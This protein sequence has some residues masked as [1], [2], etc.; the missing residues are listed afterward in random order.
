MQKESFHPVLVTGLG[1]V[2]A[3]GT[4]G[5]DLA[6]LQR[7]NILE[8]NKTALPGEE[9]GQITDFDKET[10]IGRRGLRYHTR[11]TLYLMAAA[12]MA[13]E[14]AGIANPE[15]TEPI[16]IV[17]G[18]MTSNA[19]LVADFDKT[20]LSENPT[21]VNA[22]KFPETVWNSPPSRA[23]IRFGLSGM[24]IPVCCG[25]N[26]GLDAILLGHEHIRNGDENIVLAGG[27]EEMTPYF[28]VLFDK[29]TVSPLSEGSA[30]LV[31]EQEA[32]ARARNSQPLAKI[33]G[34][35]SCYFP[36]QG[37]TA[38]EH[39]TLRRDLV[40]ETM[41]EN[42][43]EPAQVGIIWHLD[44]CEKHGQDQ[45]LLAI[46]ALKW[47]GPLPQIIELTPHVGISGGLAGALAAAIACSPDSKPLAQPNDSPQREIIISEDGQG[48]LAI[49]VVE[50]LQ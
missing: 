46:G 33:I 1:L 40:A 15:G 5:T 44:F 36:N 10:L 21:V 41:E 14:E 45:G 27:F 30:V 20:T 22:S 19:A 39:I 23:A 32:V 49:L 28:S 47:D 43:I 4:G 16:G 42:G 48:S 31:L 3:P 18:T 29:H 6:V 11:G 25:L 17:T 24:N 8:D 26:S 37:A 12:R 34:G 50:R 38:K 2:I 13:M 7:R 9:L 35:N